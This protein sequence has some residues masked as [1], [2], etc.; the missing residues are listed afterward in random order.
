MDRRIEEL[1]RVLENILDCF[2]DDCVESNDGEL[3]FVS[4]PLSEAIN[5]AEEVLYGLGNEEDL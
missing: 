3:V 4:L 1:E 5:D 2:E